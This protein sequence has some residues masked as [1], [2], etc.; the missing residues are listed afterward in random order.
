MK[1]QAFNMFLMC[2]INGGI[3]FEVFD[4]NKPFNSQFL[5]LCKVFKKL[6]IGSDKFELRDFIVTYG[7]YSRNIIFLLLTF[8]D[9]KFKKFFFPFYFYF[10]VYPTN[11]T[12]KEK[13]IALFFSI[14]IN[15]YFIFI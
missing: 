6:I 2:R 11:N 3:I 8:F 5:H 1:N 9:L 14:L 15:V 4:S 13:I 10:K 7:A 12:I